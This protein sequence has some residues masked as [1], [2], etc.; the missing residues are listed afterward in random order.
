L[1]NIGYISEQILLDL[2]MWSHMN[3]R[4]PPYTMLRKH[5]I[6]FE[7]MFQIMFMF[8]LLLLIDCLFLFYRRTHAQITQVIREYRKTGYRVP[9]TVLVCQN[10]I[11]GSCFIYV[12]VAATH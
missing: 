6:S 11:G 5:Y 4:F 1:L 8:F 7:K 12:L 2:V 10:L 3:L 9:M